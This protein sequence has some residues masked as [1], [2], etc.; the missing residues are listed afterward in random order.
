MET[1]A[2][3]LLIGSFVIIL[4]VA[5]FFFIIWLAQL[6]IDQKQVYY[7]I[8]FTESV[9]GLTVGGD[10]RFNGIQVGTVQAI[11]LNAQNPD[12]VTVIIGVDPSTPVR[13]DSVASLELQGITGVSFVQ[14]SG[15]TPEAQRVPGAG[16]ITAS[17]PTITA[18]KSFIAEVFS[19]A[20]HLVRNASDLLG[21][22]SKMLDDQTR[23]DFR[24]IVANIRTVTDAMARNSGQ[25][26]TFAANLGAISEDTKATLAEA[27]TTFA[28]LDSIAANADV[29]MKQD[30]RPMLR[31]ARKTMAELDQLAGQLNAVVAENKESINVFTERG[32]PDL[33]NLIN[34]SRRMVDNI[35]RV[36]EQ[37]EDAPG[38]I[39]FGISDNGF[40]PGE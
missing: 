23:D 3:H 12:L 39:L 33:R 38:N 11:K 17:L 35:N 8:Q 32:L 36:A 26:D 4:V 30:I 14:L 28:R 25:I 40:R 7:E 19:G 9:A 31:D 15:G 10:V 21:N 27:R 18:R 1:R 2:N 24:K 13:K 16:S 34:E 6:R 20:P 29:A 22:A 5:A 37:L